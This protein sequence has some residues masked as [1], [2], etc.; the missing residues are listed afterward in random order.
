M[1]DNETVSS[2]QQCHCLDTEGIDR[3]VSMGT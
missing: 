1:E 3:L 2:S